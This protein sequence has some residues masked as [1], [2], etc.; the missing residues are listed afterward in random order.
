MNKWCLL[1]VFSYVAHIAVPRNILVVVVVAVYCCLS[2]NI[3]KEDEREK[4]AFY[5]DKIIGY[6]HI[7][8]IEFV[9]CMRA[10]L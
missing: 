9:L 10:Y 4:D 5:S 2:I 6:V 7:V 3:P 1:Y 8:T